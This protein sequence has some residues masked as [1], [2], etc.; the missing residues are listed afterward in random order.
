MDKRKRNLLVFGA[1][2][3]VFGAIYRFYPLVGDL[4]PG[5]T[6]LEAQQNQILQYN[7]QLQKINAMKSRL[8]TLEKKLSELES[9]LFTGKTPSL[10]AVSIQKILREI[11]EKNGAQIES[12]EVLSVNT[13]ENVPYVEIPVRFVILAEID[14]LRH[15]LYGIE[16]HSRYM[17]V[18]DAQVKPRK[19]KGSDDGVYARLTVTGLMKENG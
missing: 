9:Q 18:K 8:S 6:D 13:F 2:L 5:G 16:G 15:I 17:V 4:W 11:S 12:V 3:L 10:A 19:V 1:I 14:Q 7:K